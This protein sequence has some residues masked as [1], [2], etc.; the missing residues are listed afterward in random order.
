MVIASGCGVKTPAQLPVRTLEDGRLSVDPA[1]LTLTDLASE[2]ARSPRAAL[3]RLWFSIQWWDEPAIIAAYAND[4]IELLG[5]DTVLAAWN[6]RRGQVI[7][8]RPGNVETAR[9]RDLAV[10]TFTRESRSSVP[11]QESAT[12]VQDR[13]RWRVLHDTMLEEA[14]A[15]RARGDLTASRRFRDLAARAAARRRP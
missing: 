10:V 2:P 3:L 13:G 14:L 11:G 6:L 9:N 15:A 1:P 5:R 4:V 7:G 12:L 8:S